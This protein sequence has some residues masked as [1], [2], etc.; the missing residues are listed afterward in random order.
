LEIKSFALHSNVSKSLFCVAKDI[1]NESSGIGLCVLVFYKQCKSK[2]RCDHGLVVR[3]RVSFKQR[4]DH[5]L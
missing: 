5:R 2:Q 4:C 3:S 1:L